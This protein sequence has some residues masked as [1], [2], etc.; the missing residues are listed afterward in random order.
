MK[1]YFL[2]LLLMAQCLYAQEK[3]Y[4]V[5]LI[6]QELKKG[7]DVVIRDKVQ[8]FAI[9]SRSNATY[10][11]HEVYTIF[12]ERGKR[13]S[14]EV[15]GYSK[16]EE[17]KSFTGIVYDAN[18]KIIRRLRQLD[19]YDQS[20]ISGFSLY[21]DNRL[22]AAELTQGVYPY[23]VEFD[24]EVEFKYLFYV[25]GLTLVDAEHVAVERSVYK[26][27][28]PYDDLKPRW[29][30]VNT[31]QQPDHGI[32]SRK[33]LFLEWTFTNILPVELEPFGP[34]LYEI[35]PRILAGPNHFQYDNYSG[36]MESWDSFGQWILS[37]NKDR[38]EIPMATRS[39]V[40]SMTK[41]LSDEE[42]IRKVYEYV[43]GKTRYV[44]IQIGIGGFQPFEASVVDQTGYGDCKAL[45]NYTVA[46]LK[47]AGIS[48]NY[49][50][51][52]AGKGAPGLEYDFPSTQFNHAVVA[53]PRQQDTLWL[54]CTSQTNPF[55][56]MGTFTGDR[57]ALMITDNGAQVVYTPKYPAE[58][59]IQSRKAE[60]FVDESGNAKAKI[61]TVYSGL[62]YENGGLNFILNDQFDEQKKWVENNTHIP[63]FDLNHFSVT[64]TRG[65]VPSAAVS[66]ELSVR[67]FA[68][69]GGKRM[70]VNPNLMNR[71]QLIPDKVTNRRTTVHSE[72]GYMDFD[73]I[74][75]HLPENLY[76]EFVPER[77]VL[78][79]KFGEYETSFGLEQGQLV[80]YRRMKIHKGILGPENYSE[81]VDF[82]RRV[83]KADKTEVVFLSK[84]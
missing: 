41:G 74:R 42:K 81:L 61:N 15:I 56:Y 38:Q 45:S 20:A 72:F 32:D 82:Y 52:R 4:S 44:S 14:I 67:H 84:T 70:F 22:K 60:V 79:S 50:L 9:K 49:V 17:V 59:N 57:T 80:Y 40:A 28:A 62:Q 19:I 21:E 8:T 77:T 27:S 7:S 11:V 25:P 53:I 39:E 2:S 37:L 54:E 33:N 55:G 78:K 31:N 46:L 29:K 24:Y 34:D 63:S 5:N 64:Q 51:I 10:T 71:S 68:S 26:L 47:A 13:Y 73:T 83:N 65:K 12:N 16:L 30:L 3:D 58:L 75:I 36:T 66:L 23:T 76:P 6:P 48:A 1:T 35:V 18:G 43:Q 69:S